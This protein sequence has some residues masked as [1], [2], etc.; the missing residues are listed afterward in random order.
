[1]TCV[2]GYQ[3]ALKEGQVRHWGFRPWSFITGTISIIGLMI[4]AVPSP[5]QR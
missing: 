2:D 5:M 1:M 4:F 3:M